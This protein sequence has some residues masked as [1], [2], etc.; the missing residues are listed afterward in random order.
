MHEK[1]FDKTQCPFI[2]KALFLG[3][4]RGVPEKRREAGQTPLKG[5]VSRTISSSKT[6]C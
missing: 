4:K 5:S 2:I 6:T 1:A 3:V